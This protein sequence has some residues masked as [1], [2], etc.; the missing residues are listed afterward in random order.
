MRAIDQLK[1]GIK[2]LKREHVTPPNL[3]FACPQAKERIKAQALGGR[4]FEND[5]SKYDMQCT[6]K[7]VMVQMQR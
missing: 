2:R 5:E 3:I 6:C 7:Q 4:V 1:Q